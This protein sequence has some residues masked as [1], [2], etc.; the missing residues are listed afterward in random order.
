MNEN[1][2]LNEKKEP[3]EKREERHP[4]NSY[5]PFW[6]LFND[7]FGDETSDVMRTDIVD[8]GD[9]YKMEIE[10]PG[11]DKKDVKIS[12]DKGYL[13]IS[14]K[15]NS[16]ESFH[17]GKALHRERFYGS[18][19]RSYYVGEHISKEDVSASMDKGI[20]TININK[21]KEKAEQEKY[22]DIL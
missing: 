7:C 22:I 14:A 20:L 11:S 12:L 9:S 17:S 5:H 6:S 21:P 10:V 1:I 4:M 8:V 16:N 2:N 3:I 15:V 13:T 18:Y 19:R